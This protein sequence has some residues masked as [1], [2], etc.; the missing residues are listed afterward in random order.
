MYAGPE[1]QIHFRYARVMNIIFVTMMYGVGLPILFPL[2][3]ISFT[4]IYLT[5]IFMLFYVY[6]KP[7][8]FEEGLH[9]DALLKLETAGPLFFGFGLW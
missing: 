5:E 2:A 7:P 8:A 3:C 1:F 9:E 6:R 4:I